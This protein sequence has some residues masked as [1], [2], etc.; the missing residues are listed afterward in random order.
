[1]ENI[2]KGAKLITTICMTKRL[3]WIEKL[4]LVMLMIRWSVLQTAITNP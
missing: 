4:K 2:L 3:A 1:M